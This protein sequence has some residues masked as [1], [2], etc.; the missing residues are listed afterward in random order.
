MKCTAFFLTSWSESNLE[1]TEHQ[2]SMGRLC[3]TCLTRVVVL[4]LWDC[5]RV[6]DL[7]GDSNSAV[8]T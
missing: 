4:Y 7:A 5:R 2:Q 1:A 8:R 6:G 3:A